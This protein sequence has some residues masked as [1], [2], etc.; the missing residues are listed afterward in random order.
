MI[1]ANA[2]SL[3]SQLSQKYIFRID[4]ERMRYGRVCNSISI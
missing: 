1:D 4:C 3:R 2:P